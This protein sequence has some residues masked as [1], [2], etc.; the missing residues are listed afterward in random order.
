MKYICK[1]L[2]WDLEG[3]GFALPLQSPFIQKVGESHYHNTVPKLCHSS[4]S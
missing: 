4:I 2:G 3:F 1:M